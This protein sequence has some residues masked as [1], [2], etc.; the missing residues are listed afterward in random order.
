MKSLNLAYKHY[1]TYLSNARYS[2]VPKRMGRS[3]WMMWCEILKD[4][5]LTAGLEPTTILFPAEIFNYYAVPPT[6]NN[7][8]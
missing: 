6:E 3:H 7:I 8:Y 4:T 1:K 5:M 2:I